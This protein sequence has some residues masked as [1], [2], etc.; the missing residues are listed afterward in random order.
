MP[1]DCPIGNGPS[2]WLLVSASYVGK[3]ITL[4]VIVLPNR[5]KSEPEG[6][7]KLPR[8]SMFNLEPTS[9]EYDV[10]LGTP[11]LYLLGIQPDSGGSWEAAQTTVA[12]TLAI[13]TP[14]ETEG[15]SDSLVS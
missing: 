3:P 15:A 7:P 12:N 13:M 1:L 14:E 5:L 11:W 2:D 9:E 6:S 4:A 10:V 8:A